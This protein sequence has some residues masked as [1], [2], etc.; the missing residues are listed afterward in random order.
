M[1]FAPSGLVAACGRY[2]VH[3]APRD[4]HLVPARRREAGRV[5]AGR[6]APSPQRLGAAEVRVLVLHH[7]ADKDVERVAARGRRVGTAAF[8][9]LVAAS[10]VSGPVKV[11]SVT[12]SQ[13]T[14]N[15]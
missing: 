13:S 14:W 5:R 4:V 6:C 8:G 9:Q 11:E 7:R 1:T 3:G 15:L 2:R 12:R 10:G